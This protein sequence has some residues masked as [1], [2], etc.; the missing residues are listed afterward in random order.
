MKKRFLIGIGLLLIMV[1]LI[2]YDSKKGIHLDGIY[3]DKDRTVYLIIEDNTYTLLDSRFSDGYETGKIKKESTHNSVSKMNGETI[4][5][6]TD[7]YLMGTRSGWHFEIRELDGKQFLYLQRA[8]Y[9]NYNG[10]NIGLDKIE[11]VKDN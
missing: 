6:T 7:Y 3:A 5:N 10:F 1:V 2:V 11:P 4:E 9:F 8:M